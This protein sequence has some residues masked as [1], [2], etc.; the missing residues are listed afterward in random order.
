MPDDDDDAHT[1]SYHTVHGPGASST[2]VA[3]A[4]SALTGGEILL[5]DK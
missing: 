4:A 1:L 2:A 5:V 3:P